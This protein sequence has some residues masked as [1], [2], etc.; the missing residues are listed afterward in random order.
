M[1]GAVSIGCERAGKRLRQSSC[2]GPYPPQGLSLYRR[3]ILVFTLALNSAVSLQ[4]F[5]RQK[6]S[7]HF[8]QRHPMHSRH[9]LCQRRQ[10]NPRVGMNRVGPI[11]HHEAPQLSL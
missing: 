3:A 4:F 1:V 9:F 6:M 7:R 8:S 2:L 11:V 5:L 10:G